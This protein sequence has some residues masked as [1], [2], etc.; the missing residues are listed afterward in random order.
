MESAESVMIDLPQLFYLLIILW[1]IQTYG[2]CNE[3]A[4][5]RRTRSQ[6]LFRLLVTGRTKIVR[7]SQ[8]MVS[9]PQKS[10]N[11]KKKFFCRRSLF[12][13]FRNWDMN[14]MR[15][16]PFITAFATPLER[17]AGT[18]LQAVQYCLSIFSVFLLIIIVWKDDHWCILHYSSMW[19][20]G[21]LC[22]VF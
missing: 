12:F 2:P 6:W 20:P 5:L 3:E 9:P 16:C 4:N 8:F 17:V 10:T 18:V 21:L 13:F 19:K 14:G 11:N 7:V 22:F 1:V 15:C